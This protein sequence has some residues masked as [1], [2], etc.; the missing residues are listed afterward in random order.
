[1]STAGVLLELRSVIV[2]LAVLARIAGR[3]GVPTIPLYLTAGLAVSSELEPELGPLAVSYVFL[4]A[5]VGPIAARL[6]Q[7]V[8]EAV[9]R[10]IGGRS[11]KR[12]RPHEAGP[13]PW[14]GPGLARSPAGQGA[15]IA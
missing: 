15:L 14:Q 10:G 1:V 5:V 7:L 2:G 8:S 13:E 6:A 9:V 3:L 11:S 12:A 4:L